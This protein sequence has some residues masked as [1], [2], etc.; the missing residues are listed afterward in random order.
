MRPGGRRVRVGHLERV[1]VLARQRRGVPGP[2]VG[3]P[4]H[5]RR[6]DPRVERTEVV[7]GDRERLAATGRGCSG[8]SAARSRPAA[9]GR[10]RPA[11]HGERP[12]VGDVGRQ[13]VPRV[14]GVVSATSVSCCPGVTPLTK[15]VIASRPRCT[16]VRPWK[17][18]QAPWSSKPTCWVPALVIIDMKPCS[19]PFVTHSAQAR[20]GSPTRLPGR[21]PGSPAHGRTGSR[22]AGRAGTSTGRRAGR[23]CGSLVHRGRAVPG[24]V[25]AGL[26]HAVDDA[27]PDRGKSSVKPKSSI[28]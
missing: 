9:S 17:R 27:G 13:L 19:T 8:R 26:E 25:L 11:G 3:R 24:Q 4:L 12:A 6:R 16:R 28:G 21:R 23:S 1:A 14:R 7:E 22:R 10:R 20:P 2:A 15:G 5:A 18:A